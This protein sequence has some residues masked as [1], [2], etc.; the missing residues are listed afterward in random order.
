VLHLNPVAHSLD[1]VVAERAPLGMH[2]EVVGAEVGI[3]TL[4]HSHMRNL[5]VAIERA[6]LKIAGF[7]LSAYAA[8]RGVLLADEMTLGT[9]VI[10]MGGQTTGY[11]MFR[12]GKLSTSGL[13][14]VGSHH[15]T[16]DIAQGLSTTIAHAERLKTMFG[17][18]LPF[19][20]ED[21]EMLA[22]PQL[23]ER[24]VDAIQQVPKH[25]LTSIIMPRLEETIEL[26]QR[27]MAQHTS[28]GPITRIVL[29]GGGSQLQGMREYVASVF[30]CSVRVGLPVFAQGAPESVKTGSSAVQAGLLA[31]ALKPDR[32][33]AMPASAR[34][35]IEEKQMGYARRVGRWLAEAI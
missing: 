16:T 29:T 14:A 18:V 19:A 22:V 33:I 34:A 20:H 4:E 30:G 21:R 28:I 12:N 24:G 6:H 15:L 3:I 5:T 2:G 23:G 31:L 32:K 9:L 7:G 35:R 8:G 1:G 13:V 17:S 25:V 26:L 10:D 27:D 11:A